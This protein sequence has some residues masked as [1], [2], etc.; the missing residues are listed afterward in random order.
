MRLGTTKQ[1]PACQWRREW[2]KLQWWWIFILDWPKQIQNPHSACENQ[3][4]QN[5]NNHGN[6]WQD[7]RHTRGDCFRT[8]Q[9]K[10]QHHIATIIHVLACLEVNQP[11]SS[12]RAIPKHHLLPKLTMQHT[13]T[14]TRERSWVT[15]QLQNC[16]CSRNSQS[17]SELHMRPYSTIREITYKIPYTVPRIRQAERGGGQ[18][19]Y[20]WKDKILLHNIQDE[21]HFTST[22]K[23]KQSY[24]SLKKGIHVI[25][26]VHVYGHTLRVSP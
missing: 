7:W 21:F 24:M 5:Q 17:T 10:E 16:Y 26:H 19:T 11:S 9:S 3:Q 2:V 22:K 20:W 12:K 18:I 4:F 6:G 23:W 15:L 13:V 8:H 14:C 25:K 1:S